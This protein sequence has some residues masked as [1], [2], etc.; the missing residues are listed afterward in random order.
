M[1]LGRAE[2]KPPIAR[3]LALQELRSKIIA[4]ITASP[5]SDFKIRKSV[6]GVR[7]KYA[8]S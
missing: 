5:R 3:A 4:G 2:Y 7:V 8:A 1:T 6:E